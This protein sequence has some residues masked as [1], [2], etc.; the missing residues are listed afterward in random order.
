MSFTDLACQ[1]FLLTNPVTVIRNG[2][3]AAGAATFNASRQLPTT[4]VTGR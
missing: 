2:A 1:R 4:T 3:G